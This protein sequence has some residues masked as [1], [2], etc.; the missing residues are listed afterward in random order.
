MSSV[1]APM[2]VLP[3]YTNTATQLRLPVPTFTGAPQ[4]VLEG[5]DGWANE[6][7]TRGGIVTVAGCPYP[8]TY[9]ATFDVVPVARCTGA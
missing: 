7:D 1:D 8:D 6:A 9:T 3:T 2:A 5:L 4:N